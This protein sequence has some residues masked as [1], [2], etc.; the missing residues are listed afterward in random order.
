M[1]EKDNFVV[2]DTQNIAGDVSLPIKKLQEK[3][4]RIILGN[5]NETWARKVFCEAYRSADTQIVIKNSTN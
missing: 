5:F 2:D 3:D 1:L 4:I